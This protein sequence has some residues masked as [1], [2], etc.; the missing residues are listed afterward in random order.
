MAVYFLRA[1]HVSRGKGARVTRALEIE[2]L[3]DLTGWRRRIAQLTS[4][5]TRGTNLSFRPA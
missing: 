1:R 4:E 2:R 3:P 5:S